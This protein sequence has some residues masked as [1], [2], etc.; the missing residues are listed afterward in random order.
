[1]RHHLKKVNYQNFDTLLAAFRHYDKASSEGE[2]FGLC[3]GLQVQQAGVDQD[4]IC[5]T[6]ET[7]TTSW[8]NYLHGRVKLFT[9]IG[10]GGLDLIL[11]P[12]VA[13]MVKNLPAM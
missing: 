3:V 12:L 5:R 10:G 2:S 4:H 11:A 1:M 13:Q 7:N 9:K 6:P 8:I